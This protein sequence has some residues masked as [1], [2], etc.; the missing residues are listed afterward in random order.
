MKAL[1]ETWPDINKGEETNLRVAFDKALLYSMVATGLP[2][3]APR[4]NGGFGL[5]IHRTAEIVIYSTNPWGNY[6]HQVLDNIASTDI[7]EAEPG[8][9]PV[10]LDTI[11][12]AK[13]IVDH[14]SHQGLS[15]P[16]I[17]ATAHGEVVFFWEGPNGEEFDLLAQPNGEIA[18]AGTFGRIKMYG[19]TGVNEGLPECVQAGIRWAHGR[20]WK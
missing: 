1:A 19:S 5:E 6:A 10:S 9:M 11:E 13:K 8:T 12:H 3:N 20:P 4:D 17:D 2:L 18:I 15:R 14:L 7:S 16:D